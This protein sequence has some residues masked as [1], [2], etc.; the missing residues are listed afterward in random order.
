MV[1]YSR[2]LRIG[3]GIRKR[4]KIEKVMKFVEKMKKV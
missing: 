2:E 3:A 1:N 4:E